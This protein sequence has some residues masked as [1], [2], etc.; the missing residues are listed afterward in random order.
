MTRWTV[1]RLVQLAPGAA[2]AAAAV[3][4]ALEAPGLERVLNATLAGVGVLLLWGV[5]AAVRA[6]Y[7]DRFLGTLLFAV[8]AA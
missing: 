5:A 7:P 6:R 2:L 4:V 8:A 3:V 1:P